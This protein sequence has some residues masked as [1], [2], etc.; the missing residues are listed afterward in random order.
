MPRRR[1]A[2]ILEDTISRR[3]VPGSTAPAPTSWPPATR[4]PTPLRAKEEAPQERETPPVR[5]KREPPIQAH[6]QGPESFWFET[7]PPPQGAG[8]PCF[9]VAMQVISCSHPAAKRCILRNDKVC[10][11]T[12]TSIFYSIL[13]TYCFLP[14]T[15][16]EPYL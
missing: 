7:P 1:C 9:E 3:Q 16:M 6:T 12:I 10:L 5:A 4:S 15:A 14:E 11:K 8:L 13:Q 2:Q